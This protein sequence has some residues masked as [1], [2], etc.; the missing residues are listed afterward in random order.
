M[1]NYNEQTQFEPIAQ[2]EHKEKMRLM[3]LIHNGVLLFF[4]FILF[5]CVPKWYTFFLLLLWDFSYNKEKK[6]EHKPGG[7]QS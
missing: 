5:L 2:N 1:N 3:C 4:F 6:K 7:F